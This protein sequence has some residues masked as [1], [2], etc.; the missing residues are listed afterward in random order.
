VKFYS[1]NLLKKAPT[2]K[3]LIPLIIGILI[4]YHLNIQ[5][6]LMIFISLTSSILTLPFFLLSNSQNFYYRSLKGVFIFLV[7]IGLG[8]CLA[9]TK[10]I[11][12]RP[13]WIGNYFKKDVPIIVTLQENLAIKEKSFK[14][15][16]TIN[17]VYID[18][19]W[20][21]VEG[22]VLLYFKK[23]STIPNL[24]YGSQ[25]LITKNL[26]K[27]INSGNP[28]GFN[29]ASYCSFQNIHFQGFLKGN[30]Y[31]ILSSNKRSWFTMV[32]IDIRTN[33]L[34]ILKSNIINNNELSI[35]EALLIG[36]R[37]ELD[38]DLV[39]AYSNTGVVHIIA[40]SGLHLGM[41][42]IL[43]VGLFKPFKRFKL[44][45]ILKPIVIIFVLWMFSFI[46][47]M[48]P[49]I[50]RS[51]I[52]F[53]CI[54]VGE[55]FGKRNN[56]YN[57]LALSAFIILIVSPFSLWDVG[58][59]LSYS[60]VLSIVIF[61][62]YI[63]KWVYFK[64]KLLSAFW[65]L[66]SVTLA[67]QILTL[68]IVLYHF[69]QFPLLFLV[70]NIFAVTWSGIILYAELLLLLFS[71]WE[72]VAHLIGILIEWMIKVMNSFILNVNNLPFSVWESLQINIPQAVFIFFAI[73]GF[74]F[75][76]I[77]RKNNGFIIGLFFLTIFFVIR[78]IDFNKRNTQNKLV[79]YNVPNHTAI[80]LIEGRKYQFIGDSILNQ[81]GFLKNFHIK[82]S[83][84]LHRVTESISLNNIYSNSNFIYSKNKIIAVI[85]APITYRGNKI[86]VDAVLI[87]KN[88]KIYIN[89]LANIF[90]C[91]QYV[92][93]GSNPSWKINK[94]QMD[95]DSL[96]LQRH[97]SSIQGAFEM[98]L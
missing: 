95:C 94:W 24:K 63:K 64:N 10:N 50:V 90:D 65:Q 56:I 77:N 43:I 35:A 52:M 86:K 73:V 36:Y 18:K 74:S 46:A 54:A 8:G 11:S 79:V 12:N 22:D 14:A 83:R 40:I 60:A 42:Y 57:G 17:A 75:W 49:S 51:A 58:F 48:A 2:L 33:V 37:D 31:S 72:P 93:D 28:G 96:H 26:N 81:Y 32:L 3:F 25:I 30:S 20:Q 21:N 68:P 7:F 69:H 16:A 70:T 34:Q 66:N 53:T 76:L 91:D 5:F 44:S 59:Q 13:S 62:P 15:L 80:D 71:W 1:N 82:P 41:I 92:F 19:H 61:S 45:K 39:K 97:I 47:G 55:F 6:S 84:V 38:R 87:T 85:N 4:E 98:N 9:Y 27:I 29:Y 88:P 78:G 23:D 89:Q 67:A